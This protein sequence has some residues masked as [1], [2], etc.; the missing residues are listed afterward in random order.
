MVTSIC[1][2]KTLAKFCLFLNIYL[3]AVL[4]QNLNTQKT[5][6]SKKY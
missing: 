6:A 5:K 1:F 3:G 2:P 4:S